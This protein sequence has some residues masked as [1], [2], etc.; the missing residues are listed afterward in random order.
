[1]EVLKK[2]RWREKEEKRMG[3]YSW[4]LYW[5]TV[6]SSINNTALNFRSS[7]YVTP[8][9]R[10]FRFAIFRIHFLRCSGRVN[11]FWRSGV[12]VF[13]C[14]GVPVFR[15]S[16]GP[17]FIV[18]QTHI[19]QGAGRRYCSL[20]RKTKLFRKRSV[21][22]QATHQCCARTVVRLKKSII[23]RALSVLVPF[24][25][26]QHL[27]LHNRRSLA[28]SIVS[29]PSCYIYKFAAISDSWMYL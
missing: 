11:L 25:Y 6:L 28:Q 5:A 4:I 26:K 18:L 14:F 1:M 16:G 21:D 20:K 23:V 10:S 2:R 3:Q 9:S 19:K 7:F 22:A 27:K 12:S 29:V 15:C 13:R 8:S 24:R 17:L